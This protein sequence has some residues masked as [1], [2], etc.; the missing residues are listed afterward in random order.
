MR[1]EGGMVRESEGGIGDGGGREALVTDEGG[2]VREPGDIGEGEGGMAR[3][4][5]GFDNQ[6]SSSSLIYLQVFVSRKT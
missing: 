3:E 5:E 2:M 4:R 1:E 6:F